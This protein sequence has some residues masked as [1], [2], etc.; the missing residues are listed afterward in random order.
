M[1][2]RSALHLAANDL[3]ELQWPRPTDRLHR[4]NP[5]DE[6][7]VAWQYD[8]QV[9]VA[10]GSNEPTDGKAFPQHVAATLE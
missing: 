2:D 6:H 9:R 10:R 7:L 1:E 3:I 8:Q 4:G 5:E